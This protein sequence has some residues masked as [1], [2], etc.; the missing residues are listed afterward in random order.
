MKYKI[1]EYWLHNLTNIEIIETEICFESRTKTNQTNKIPTKTDFMIKNWLKN[2][3]L[4]VTTEQKL[5]C[6]SIWFLSI[7][8]RSA[9]TP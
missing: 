7:N 8:L 1:E 3:Y 4:D 9:K 2:E 5:I 6:L